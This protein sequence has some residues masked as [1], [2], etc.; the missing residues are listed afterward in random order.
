MSALVLL[1]VFQKLSSRTPGYRHQAEVELA[2]RINKFTKLN[3]KL[4]VNMPDDVPTWT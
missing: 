2:E 4:L 1:H 3:D